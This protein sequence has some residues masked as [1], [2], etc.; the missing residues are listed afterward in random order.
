MIVASLTPNIIGHFKPYNNDAKMNF[1]SSFAQCMSSS[2]FVETSNSWIVV[3]G[4]IFVGSFTFTHFDVC[5]IAENEE[6]DES[7]IVKEM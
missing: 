5:R 3:R 7:I 1:S 6:R 2:E 4:I